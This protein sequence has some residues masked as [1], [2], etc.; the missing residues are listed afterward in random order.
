MSD[1]EMAAYEKQI[2]GTWIHDTWTH[3]TWIH[4]TLLI[5]HSYPLTY[6]ALALHPTPTEVVEERWHLLSELTRNER[7]ERHLAL[8]AAMLHRRLARLEAVAIDQGV[9]CGEEG[10]GASR[11]R[12][13]QTARCT[14]KR[15]AKTSV[16]INMVYTTIAVDFD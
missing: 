7:R 16:V 1:S 6:R 8:H 10:G 9:L 4:A 15:L 11:S 5:D 3:A 12:V 13:R 2:A 14:S